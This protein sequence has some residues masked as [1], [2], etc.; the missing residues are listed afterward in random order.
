MGN[1]SSPEGK[2]INLQK[3]YLHLYLNE[4]RD[5]PLAI[6]YKE[7]Q[8]RD[9]DGLEK[10]LGILGEAHFATNMES[11]IAE[12]IIHSYT[13]FAIEGATKMPNFF[14]FFSLA[15][16]PALLTYAFA[17]ERTAPPAN[18]LANI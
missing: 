2:I 18:S 1:S 6:R 15:F 5:Y 9:E 17:T 4:R 7:F 11:I 12:K 16:A 8:A 13:A 14:K 3:E 10:R